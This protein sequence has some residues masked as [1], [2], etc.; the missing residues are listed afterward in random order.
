MSVTALVTPLGRLALISA[1]V[2]AWLVAPWH[3]VT[4]SEP[5]R[6][7]LI[8]AA[9]L[10]NFA[11][12]T[13]WP[14]RAFA[15]S[16]AALEICVL[17]EDPFGAALDAIAEKEIEGRKVTIRRLGEMA[18]ADGCHLLFIASSQRAQLRDI[19]AR[20][21]EQP[22]LTVADVPEFTGIGGIITLKVLSDKVRFEINLPAARRAE[23][24][25]SSKLLRL[26]TASAATIIWNER[27]AH[28]E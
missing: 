8:K 9:F 2:G 4:A 11:K 28:S 22:V 13:Y 19:I 5:S 17:G 23:L 21:D 27:D 24:H 18:A 25:L 7:Y 15:D 14:E 20:L 12:F 10:Y 1:L 3:T 26:S 6:E 16:T